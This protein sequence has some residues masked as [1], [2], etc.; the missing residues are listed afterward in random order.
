MMLGGISSFYNSFDHNRAVKQKYFS[1]IK[2]TSRIIT[3]LLTQKFVAYITYDR[4]YKLLIRLKNPSSDKS[5]DK[6]KPYC[7]VNLLS[8]SLDH[9]WARSNPFLCN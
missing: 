7:F 5:F 4:A 6:K 3:S 2:L 1:A 9:P 8:I